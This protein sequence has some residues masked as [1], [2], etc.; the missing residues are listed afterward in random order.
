VFHSIFEAADA[1]GIGAI[2]SRAHDEQI[3]EPLIENNFGRD[4]TIGTTEDG[5]QWVLALCKVVSLR[6]EVV[7]GHPSFDEAF[8]AIHQGVPDLLDG[9]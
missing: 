4:A 9:L 8:V 3:P 6:N 1:H 2:S 5:N 7:G